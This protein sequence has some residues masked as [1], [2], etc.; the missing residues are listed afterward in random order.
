MFVNVA[1]SMLFMRSAKFLALTI[2]LFHVNL[3]ASTPDV[4]CVLGFDIIIIIL[5]TMS[6]FLKIV[7]IGHTHK[8]AKHTLNMNIAILNFSLFVHLP[9]YFR[10]R[11]T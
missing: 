11:F 4:L 1:R 9:C 3:R 10:S 6:E 8:A 5:Y 7:L 2:Q